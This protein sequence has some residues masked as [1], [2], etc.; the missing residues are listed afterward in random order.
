MKVNKILTI[1]WGFIGI[2][3]FL[4][5]CSPPDTR[6][7]PTEEKEIPEGITLEKNTLLLTIGEKET[8]NYTIT[9]A[10]DANKNVTW[11]STNPAVVSVSDDGTV[12]AV[13]FTT[14]GSSTDSAAA[15]GTAMIAV[16]TADGNHSD[17]ITVNTTMASQ[18]DIISLP[19][20]K[21]QFSKYFM[22]GNI[23][24]P[25]D[26]V[27]AAGINNARL[28]RHYN[29]LT[30]E[31]NMKPL[32]L[33][34]AARGSYNTNNLDIAMRMV[35]AAIADGIKVQGHALLW[36]SQI[37][38]W[39]ANLRSSGTASDALEYMKDYIAY[40]VTYFK[41]KIYAWDVLNEAFS[42]SISASADWRVSMRNGSSDGNPWFMRIGA[43]F[44]YEGF[45]AARLADP[46]AI[47]YYNDY[48]L[49]NANKARVVANMV[50]DINQQ[51]VSDPV[52]DNR[53]LIE[54]IG[55]QSHHNTGISVNNIKNS[56]ALFRELGVKISISELDVLSQSWAEYSGI[57]VPDNNGKI[58]AANLYGQY[59]KLFLENAD[60]IERVTFWGVCDEQSWRAKGRPLL[61]EGYP[62]AKAKPAYYK[63]IG[64]LE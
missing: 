54:G 46:A 56:L 14:G 1:L 42:D 44:V 17:I 11:L 63:N 31:N 37:P 24:N 13:S 6:E 28:T 45:K 51:W 7:N 55:M 49:D 39:Q 35:N 21:D 61:F 30:H 22:I 41:G 50:R 34:N 5:A 48:N 29:I 38:D 33:S 47:L 20:L 23:Y 58:S 9:P 59:F 60:I 19:P 40:I 62:A 36:H 43:D 64:A 10:G 2:L 18:E 27:S 4:P 12:T 15:T 16:T 26:A 3:I 32:Y 52:Y 57:A 25:E 53:F 8:L